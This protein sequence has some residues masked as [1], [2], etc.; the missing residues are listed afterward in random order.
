ME[1]AVSLSPLSTVSTASS[2][3]KASHCGQSFGRRSGD[4]GGDALRA[5]RLRRRAQLLPPGFWQPGPPRGTSFRLRSC[6]HPKTDDVA[7][8]GDASKGGRRFLAPRAGEK[9]L[10]FQTVCRSVAK[11]L[12]RADLSERRKECRKAAVAT[13]WLRWR[14]ACALDYASWMR[15]VQ[16]MPCPSMW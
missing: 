4:N 3:S 13:H 1:T 8:T 6:Q 10:A 9:P 12:F 14:E 15:Q 7:W 11:V 2:L 16:C 5:R